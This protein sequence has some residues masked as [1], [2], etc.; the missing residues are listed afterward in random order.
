[1]ASFLLVLFLV[2]L[3]KSRKE[4][5]GFLAEERVMKERLEESRSSEDRLSE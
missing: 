5:A 1:M 3:D 4:Q 2:D